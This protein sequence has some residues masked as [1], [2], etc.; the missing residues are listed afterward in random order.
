M[1]NRKTCRSGWYECD[2][3]DHHDQNLVV[4]IMFGIS[5]WLGGVDDFVRVLLPRIH[6]LIGTRVSGGIGCGEVVGRA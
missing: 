6:D 3:L 5:L 1:R 2:K 4:W